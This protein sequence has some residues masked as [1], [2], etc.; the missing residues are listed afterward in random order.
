MTGGGD[1]PSWQL[2][3]AYRFQSLISAEKSSVGLTRKRD[4]QFP[5]LKVSFPMSLAFYLLISSRNDDVFCH[6]FNLAEM[7]GPRK[8]YV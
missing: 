6:F 1:F 4:V 5:N 2:I 7:I 3:F 8:S